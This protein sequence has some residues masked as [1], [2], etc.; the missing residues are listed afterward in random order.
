MVREG[1]PTQAGSDQRDRHC[2][3]HWYEYI[4]GKPVADWTKDPSPSALGGIGRISGSDMAHEVTAGGPLP[5]ALAGRGGGIEVAT[6]LAIWLPN[7]AGLDH[8]HHQTT[9]EAL[10]IELSY[11]VYGAEASCHSPQVRE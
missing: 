9:I 8:L 6:E 7:G 2:P 5:A 3:S 4:F 1:S 10:C 11:L